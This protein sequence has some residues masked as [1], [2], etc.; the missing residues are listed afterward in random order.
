[1]SE[2]KNMRREGNSGNPAPNS[3]KTGHKQLPNDES[4]PQPETSNVKLQIT[5]M[6]PHAHHLHKAPGHGWRH[7]VF[8]FLMLFL[9]VF[10]GF[11]A[12][13]WR[14]HIVENNR[15]KQYIRSFYQ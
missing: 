7:Y 5:N 4:H 11:L 3:S 2:E 6:E 8:E 1:M 9:A 15:E 13:N 10:C 12:E 14:E